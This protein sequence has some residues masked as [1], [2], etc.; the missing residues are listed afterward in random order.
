MKTV[1]D[2][3]ILQSELLFWSREILCEYPPF[4]LYT[5]LSGIYPFY[6]P[7]NEQLVTIRKIRVTNQEIRQNKFTQILNDKFE[8]FMFEKTGINMG[9]FRTGAY[10]AGN[11]LEFDSYYLAYAVQHDPVPT[12]SGLV[13]DISIVNGEYEKLILL[14][15]D[16]SK[17]AIQ[18]QFKLIKDI[19]AV[20]LIMLFC[21]Y[22]CVYVPYLIKELSQIKK[23]QIITSLIPYR[24]LK[25]P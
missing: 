15:D 25:Q 21:L 14:A 3:R 13:T 2:R 17:A 10:Q 12:W 1:I 16:D 23:M 19:T 22:I 20:Y 7:K 4:E 9:A 8:T 5:L 18:S 11:S 6:S 24:S